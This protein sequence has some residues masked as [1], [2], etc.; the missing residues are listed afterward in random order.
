MSISPLFSVI[1]PVYNVEQYLRKCLDSICS[2]TYQNLECQFIQ[3]HRAHFT[4]LRRG[5]YKNGTQH[6]RAIWP[7]QAILQESSF[8]QHSSLV[9]QTIYKT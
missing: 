9:P 4:G 8:P 7:A 3:R 2:Q 1:V 5:V 6:C